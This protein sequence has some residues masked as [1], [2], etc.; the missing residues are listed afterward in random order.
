MKLALLV[1][2]WLAGILLGFHV[3]A[4]LLPVALLLLAALPAGMLLRLVGRSLWPV[5]LVV[6]LLAGLLRIE[7]FEVSASPLAVV[8]KETV[9]L[10]GRIANDPEATARRI[11]FV[12]S[13]DEIDRAGET[14][15]PD[16]KGLVYASPPLSLLSQRGDP[17]FRYGDTLVLEGELRQPQVF[18]DFDYP[19]YLSHQGISGILWVRN[20]ELISQGDGRPA[21]AWK[22]WMFGL[23]RN[24]AE[25][26]QEALPEPIRSWP[27]RCCWG[28]AANSRPA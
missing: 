16:A 17:Y 25:E 7:A 12:V 3:E 8:E 23:R 28:F 27:R 5:L 14:T 10:Q 22:G 9:T 18:E 2:A 13:V 26:L 15:R 11:K 24:L 21:S 6:V 4:D 1:G 20:T 19:S